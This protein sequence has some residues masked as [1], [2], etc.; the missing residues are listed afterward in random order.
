MVQQQWA[1]GHRPTP[2]LPVASCPT[3]RAYT[4]IQGTDYW[5]YQVEG[6]A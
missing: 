1:R 5:I 6:G 2:C 4:V 3:E